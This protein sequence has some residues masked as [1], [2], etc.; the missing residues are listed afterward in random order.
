M[1][2][3]IAKSIALSNDGSKLYVANRSTGVEV[4]DITDPANPKQLANLDTSGSAEDVMLS[5]DGKT[6]YVADGKAGIKVIR[7][8]N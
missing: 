2:K 1:T 4:I 3:S 6:L 7:I 8:D 5:K